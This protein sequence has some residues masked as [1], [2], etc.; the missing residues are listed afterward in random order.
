MFKSCLF[1]LNQKHRRANL[2][3]AFRERVWTHYLGN[4]GKALCFCCEK[5]LIT[6]FRFECAHIIADSK[7]GSRDVNNLLPCCAICN[8]SM[9]TMNLFVFKSKL[10]NDYYYD[11]KNLSENQKNIIKYYNDKE[12]NIT[13]QDY[14][15]NFNEWVKILSSEIIVNVEKKNGEILNK[16]ECDCGFSF[17]YVT[18]KKWDFQLRCQNS[19]QNIID[20][21]CDHIPCLINKKNFVNKTLKL[22]SFKSWIAK[23][24]I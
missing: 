9:G 23:Q 5:N 1:N 20:V 4:R 17:I 11:K 6:P 21:I 15:E 8:R 18:K 13:C 2:P 22:K 24:K 7:G 16:F 19:K 14:L 10:H 3:H 12:D